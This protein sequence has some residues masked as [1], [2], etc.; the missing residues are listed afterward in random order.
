VSRYLAAFQLGHIEQ[1]WDPY[2]GAGTERI[3]TSDVSKA[4]P[5]PDAGVGAVTYLLEILTG[6]IGSQRRWRTM[7]WLVILFGIM[8]VPLGAVSIFFIIIQPIV[9]GT[10]CALCLVGAAAMVV[11][12]P[13]SLDELVATGQFL[14]QRRR[15]GQALWPIFLH[16]DTAA[17]GRKS[18]PA[19]FEQPVKRIIAEIWG[20]GVNL[21][22]T[23]LACVAIGVWLMCS[24][25]IFGTGE[26]MAFSDHLLGALI[27]TV[28][29]TACAELARPVR[30]LNVLFGI[31]LMA[32]PWMMEGGSALADWAGVLTGLALI[33]LSIP[34]GRIA[35]RYGSWDKVIF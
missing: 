35:N 26:P 19:D 29:V 30:Y 5:V 24:R 16:G 31:A 25:L 15:Q 32:A 3:I 14:A 23:L 34:R 17:G 7:P 10:W 22:W 28:S 33:L 12:I 20:G 4:W 9:I 13:Y 21:P 1:A 2:F 18:E 6:L 11:Q 8:I 27:I